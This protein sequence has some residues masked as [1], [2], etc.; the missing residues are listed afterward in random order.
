MSNIDSLKY[1]IWSIA[2]QRYIDDVVLHPDGSFAIYD[3]SLLEYTDPMTENNGYSIER[4]TG[5][6][7]KHG[8]LIYKGDVLEWDMSVTPVYVQ[9]N[10]NN[11]RFA[12][13]RFDVKGWSISLIQDTAS[14]YTIIGNIHTLLI[15]K[16]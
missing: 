8:N 1:R 7:D 11:C 16:E 9:W 3:F 5:L 10:S 4:C 12:L 2:R 15:D 14:R 6:K 13:H